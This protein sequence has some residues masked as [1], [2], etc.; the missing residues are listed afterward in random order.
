MGSP[1]LD[2]NPY[3]ARMKRIASTDPLEALLARFRNI[4]NLRIQHNKTTHLL[5]LVESLYDALECESLQPQILFWV[6]QMM[7]LLDSEERGLGI[8]MSVCR[9]DLA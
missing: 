7:N 9:C 5:Y 4:S 6:C 8:G 2:M 3:S 1:W